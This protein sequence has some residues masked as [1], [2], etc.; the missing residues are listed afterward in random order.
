MKQYHYTITIQL[1]NEREQTH[2]TTVAAANRT[3]A[4]TMAFEHFMYLAD[5]IVAGQ[6]QE[7]PNPP[8]FLGSEVV[9]LP[10]PA[11]EGAQYGYFTD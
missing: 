3:E 4:K 8:I 9:T 10:I 6:P 2:E 11:S 1:D 5:E 7:N